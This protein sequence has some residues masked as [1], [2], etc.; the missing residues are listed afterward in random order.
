MR[1][2]ACFLYFYTSLSIGGAG[3]G[4]NMYYVCCEEKYKRKISNFFHTFVMRK[5]LVCIVCIVCVHLFA[6][7][8]NRAELISLT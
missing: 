8:H 5:V 4:W 6:P 2:S 7:N 1:A 3:S